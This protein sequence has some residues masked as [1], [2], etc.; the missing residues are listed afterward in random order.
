MTRIAIIQRDGEVIKRA[1]TYD[2]EETSQLAAIHWLEEIWRPDTDRFV[3]ICFPQY[4][5]W[6]GRFVI[7]EELVL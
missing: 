6:A 3:A 4:D 5:V 7:E 1:F 2:D